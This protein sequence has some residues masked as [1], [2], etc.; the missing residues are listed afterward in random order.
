MRGFIKKEL[1]KATLCDGF[2]FTQNMKLLKLPSSAS[3][4]TY[5]YGNKL[6][7]LHDDPYQQH[8]LND[9][10]KEVELIHNMV[11]IMRQEDAPLEQYERMGVYAELNEDDLQRQRDTREI[12]E[13]V[14]VNFEINKKQQAQ[15][16]M[17]KTMVNGKVNVEDALNSIANTKPNLH[18]D[19]YIYGL[20]QKIIITMGLPKTYVGMMKQ[21]LDTAD[22]NE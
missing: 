4:S 7:N 2:S 8:A 3:F 10:Q 9:K 1:T 6:Y 22:V 11:E 12:S 13:Q 16:N 14:H 18:A 19:E 5:Q 21:M 20:F 17:L 15:I